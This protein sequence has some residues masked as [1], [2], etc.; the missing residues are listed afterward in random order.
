MKLY[1]DIWII[2]FLFGFVVSEEDTDLYLSWI[3]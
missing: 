3:F 2:C 1:V